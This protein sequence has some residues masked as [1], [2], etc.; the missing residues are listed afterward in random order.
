M[1]SSATGCSSWT[2]KIGSAFG[3]AAL[4]SP[5]S[6]LSPRNYAAPTGV[7]HRLSNSQLLPSSSPGFFLRLRNG[8]TIPLQIDPGMG[9][10]ALPCNSY[11]FR[12][13]TLHGNE[14]TIRYCKVD[15]DWHTVNAQREGHGHVRTKGGGACLGTFRRI[16]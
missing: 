2:T 16:G 3:H 10:T 4:E 5:Q 1:R 13:S 6:R 8:T 9:R 11:S 12:A 14:T 7:P 15:P